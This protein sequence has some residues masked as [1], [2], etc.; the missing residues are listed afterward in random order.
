MNLIREGQKVGA[1]EATLLGMLKIMPFSYGLVIDQVYDSGAVFEPA[2][3]DITQEH[4]LERISDVRLPPP[5][6]L[7]P[8]ISPCCK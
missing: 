3:L 2:V 8:L 1:S 4:L 5:S 7:F 6:Q